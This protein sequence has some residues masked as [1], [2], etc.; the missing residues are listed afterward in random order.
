MSTQQLTEAA[1][2]GF[3]CV[4][5]ARLIQGLKGVWVERPLS[6]VQPEGSLSMPEGYARPSHDLFAPAARGPAHRRSSP[7]LVN[8]SGGQC[9]TQPAR[10]TVFRA[11]SCP[12]PGPHASL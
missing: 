10:P 12:G 1:C 11:M 4:P 8:P 2:R 6:A 7:L 3:W 9:V 5:V